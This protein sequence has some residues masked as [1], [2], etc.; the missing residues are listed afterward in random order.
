M[1]KSCLVLFT[2]SSQRTSFDQTIYSVVKKLLHQKIPKW[3]FHLQSTITF[4]KQNRLA[5]SWPKMF[6][7]HLCMHLSMFSLFISCSQKYPHWIALLL[8]WG[9]SA[10][11]QAGQYPHSQSWQ[12]QRLIL[13]PKRHP[14]HR[15]WRATG[16]PKIR[17]NDG[18]KL[19]NKVIRKVSSIHCLGF[20][21]GWILI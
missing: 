16:R 15:S 8:F 10:S 14:L 11:V 4:L 1:W 2:H 5:R 20:G 18:A 17:K 12:L 7:F 3:K 21:F 9:D 6:F 13:T 19:K